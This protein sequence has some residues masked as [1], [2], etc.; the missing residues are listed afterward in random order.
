V[1]KQENADPAMRD[2]RYKARNSAY[3]VYACGHAECTWTW[4]PP[5]E[6]KIEV[7]V[8]PAQAGVHVS[9]EQAEFPLSRE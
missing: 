1:G 3:E 4:G 9:P 2:R 7:I 5:N 6:M 8:T